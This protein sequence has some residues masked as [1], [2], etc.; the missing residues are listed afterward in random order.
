M[1]YNLR[2][3]EKYKKTG[4]NR[5]LLFSPFD[6]KI[7]VIAD[8]Y[9]NRFVT[10]AIED[11]II[12]GAMNL[13]LK[14]LMNATAKRVWHG[15]TLE[16]FLL[17][18]DTIFA[19]R[20]LIKIENGAVE[21]N[22]ETR[23]TNL[24]IDSFIG[25]KEGLWVEHINPDGPIEN[26][27]DG[28]KMA[29]HLAF[30]E[31]YKDAVKKYFSE[32]ANDITE[33][34]KFPK[35]LSIKKVI[36]IEK[37]KEKNIDLGPIIDEL[38][39]I[40][41]SLSKEKNIANS[42]ASIDIL[43][44]VKYFGSSIGTRIKTND[45]K[46]KITLKVE[47][48]VGENKYILT[49]HI[50]TMGDEKID[51]KMISE[52]HK[53][54][55]RRIKELNVAKSQGAVHCYAVVSGEGLGTIIHEAVGHL[56]EKSL[57]TED[58]WKTFFS[59]LNE[60]VTSEKVTIIDDPNWKGG[61]GSIKYDAYGERSKKVV[62]IKNGIVN[63]MLNDNPTASRDGKQSNAHARAM[64]LS[65]VEI[66]DSSKMDDDEDLGSG[67][68]TPRMTNTIVEINTKKYDSIDDLTIAAID[69]NNNIGQPY[70]LKLIGHKG[71]M[72]IETGQFRFTPK[73]AYRVY[74]DGREEPIRDVIVILSPL[75]ALNNIIASGKELK[76]ERGFCGRPEGSVTNDS[77]APDVVME[78]E[79]TIA[80]ED[81]TRPPIIEKPK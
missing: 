32:I 2:K 25:N 78:I 49:E 36:D 17:C 48:F 3:C 53:N 22:N 66:I 71:G 77:F 72:V 81:K 68:P 10:K 28:F 55:L 9:S 46:C 41:L 45:F 54:I 13:E 16:H 7:K 59:R 62:L 15:H 21:L 75:E 6:E 61:W 76:C 57:N 20:K 63:E 23:E 38:K 69:K 8:S 39:K 50:F 31:A 11:K 64:R 26:S 12:F 65:S 74:P 79:T 5:F 67:D 24:R 19:Q 42:T 70:A 37:V 44:E 33:R 73:E 18:C 35:L 1:A 47:T 40:S 80:V 51:K 43:D 52:K 34:I 58:E 4:S 56:F 30:D 29:F 27:Y 60:S 14:R